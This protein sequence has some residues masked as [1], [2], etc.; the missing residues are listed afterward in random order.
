MNQVIRLIKEALAGVGALLLGIG[1]ISAVGA[2]APQTPSSSH[3][4]T[5]GR[6]EDH[7]DQ[8]HT[9]E[10]EWA[11]TN[12]PETEVDERH[13]LVLDHPGTAC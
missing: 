10:L 12:G 9:P 8:P 5:R 6:T 3:P 2:T 4:L 13:V 1:G 7:E 11:E